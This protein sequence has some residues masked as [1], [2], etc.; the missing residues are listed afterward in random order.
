MN[1]HSILYNSYKYI[2]KIEKVLNYK[3]SLRIVY[4]HKVNC[5]D[6]LFYFQNGMTTT[7][8]ENQLKY[9]KANFKVISLNEALIKSNNGD[10]LNGYL[11]ITFDDGFSDC[12]DIIY[13][14][15][16]QYDI[17][18]T[19]F[20]IENVINNQDFMWRNKLILLDNL[21]NEELKVELIE[22]FKEEFKVI[23][24]TN[25]S[26]FNLSNSWKMAEKETYANFL[27]NISKIGSLQ[28]K[29]DTYKPYLND[30]QIFEMLNN[31]QE[32]GSHS[33]SHPFC[34]QLNIEEINEEVIESVNR[35]NNK[36]G[37][38]V[39]AFSYPFGNR[40][41]DNIENYILQKSKLK[42]LLGINDKLNNLLEPEKWE[43]TGME[44]DYYKSL[45]S[46]YLKS[47]YRNCI[48]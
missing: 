1:L 45:N 23:D 5:N 12:Y 34:D 16:K 36:F 27:W 19:F 46:F 44:K 13:P 35:L 2:P 25:N 14:L 6:Q 41:V 9:F 3:K 15:L 30:C 29:L 18:A 7:V 47:F 37:I 31:G 32:I 24:Y 22:I 8:F 26:F 4:Y 20:L 42:V 17:K 43:R 10:N 11:C 21:V 33:K 28:E 38:N 48:S 39:N 40:A